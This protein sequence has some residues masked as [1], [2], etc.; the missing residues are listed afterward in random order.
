MGLVLMLGLAVSVKSFG[1][2][3]GI[4]SMLGQGL[5]TLRVRNA[6]VYEKVRVRNISKPLLFHA[7]CV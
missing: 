4:G 6:W 5:E 2:K 1:L 3:L 7:L